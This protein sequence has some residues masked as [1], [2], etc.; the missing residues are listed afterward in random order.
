YGPYASVGMMHIILDMIRE[1]FPL[2]TCNL[3]LSKENIEKGKY[4]VC[5]E[6]QLGNCK[7]PCENYQ[8][9]EDYDRNLSDIKDI[10]NGKISMVTT[11]LKQQMQ[12]AVEEMDFE[13]AHRAKTKLVK[14][15]NYQSRSTV[16]S[17]SISNVDVFSIAS[18][19]NF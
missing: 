5:L 8:S 6:Y 9:E 1:L 16:V 18:E 2:R 17:S 3:N 11:R 15:S 12:S 19:D 13:N 14:R 10:L 4:K 7:G